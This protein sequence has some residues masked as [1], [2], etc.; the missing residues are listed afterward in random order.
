MQSISAVRLVC[1]PRTT[2][3]QVQAPSHMPQGLICKT[4]HPP[5]EIHIYYNTK[6]F[7]EYNPHFVEFD[8]RTNNETKD[9][10]L[11]FYMLLYLIIGGL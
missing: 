8:K 9:Y 11:R 4:N 5:N 3:S 6:V 1:E 7:I 2:N 10:F